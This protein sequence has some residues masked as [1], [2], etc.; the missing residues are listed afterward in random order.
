MSTMNFEEQR[1]KL[2]KALISRGI[3]HSPDVIRAMRTVP[4]EKFLPEELRGEA[5]IDTPLPI[6]FGQ[7]ISAPHMVAIMA[8][9]LELEEGLKV[10]EVGTGSGYHAA[11]TAETV[12][13]RNAEKRGHVYTLEVIPELISFAEKGLKAAKYS[14]RVTVILG[15]GSLGYRAKSSYDRVLVTASAPKV[16]K[17]LTEQ[18]KVGGILVI[19]V[20]GLHFFQR[21]LKVR[22][23]SDESISTENL[24]GVAFVPLRGKNGWTL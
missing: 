22:K 1:E 12:C 21:L 6:G 19:P 13:P 7:T 10:L 9:A 5:Y 20:G 11:V 8:E 3:L 18:L 2:V 17:A 15:D 24:G 23:N 14:S 16:P 4:R